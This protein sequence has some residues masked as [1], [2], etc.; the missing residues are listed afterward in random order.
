MKEPG[1]GVGAGDRPLT[2]AV[3][4]ADLTRE[5]SVPE[6]HD[7]RQGQCLGVCDGHEA[8]THL[9]ALGAPGGAAVQLQLRRP[10]EADDLDVLPQHAAGMAG[11]ES[12]HR[13]FLGR[14]PA[15]EVR[16]GVAPPRT[17]GDLPLGENPVQEPV[18]IAPECFRNPWKI[19]RVQTNSNDVHV[20]APA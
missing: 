3:D 18:A 17:I 6:E 2:T 10:A 19:R 14:K 12:L 8:A 7:L 20:R 15:G 11:A 9:H 16:D 1:E 5:W 13:R 4:A